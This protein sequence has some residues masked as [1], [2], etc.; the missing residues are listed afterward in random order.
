MSAGGLADMICCLD[1]CFQQV[2]MGCVAIDMH[3]LYILRLYI[4]S[5]L[6][7]EWFVVLNVLKLLLCNF[8]SFKTL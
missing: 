2:L 6:W 4:L 1:R 5:V 3:C 7:P 8:V